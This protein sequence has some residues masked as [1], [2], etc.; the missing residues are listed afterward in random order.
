MRFKGLDLN[1]LVALD[2]LMSERSL[3]SAA[4][5][6][7]LSQ[8]AMSAAVS[9]LR[10][11]FRDDLFTM[12]GRE[13]C[14]T[15]RAEGLA[16]VVRDVLLQI[17]CSIISREPFNPA[18]S[19]RRFRIILSDFMTLVFLERVVARVAR[20]APAVSFDLL[21]PDNDPNELLRRGEVD[22]LL[23]PDLFMANPHPREKLFDEKLVCVTCPGND[24][25]PQ[26]LTF[27]QYMSMGHVV[28]M[29]GRSLR[30]SIDEWFLLERGIKRR[31][32]VVVPGFSLIPE[33]LRGTNR[34]A[35]MPLRL[36][37]YFEKTTPLRIVNL[38]LPLADFT[39]S[40]QWPA[41]Q[42]ADPASV[43]MRQILIEEASRMAAE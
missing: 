15:P 14:L 6:I 4:R 35:T 9:R 2:A 41:L 29:F 32:E 22:F 31:I 1:L 7:N 5:T 13:L 38:P 39:E 17:Q 26:E 12:N 24:A 42:N 28:A 18:Q 27:E 16:P 8:P 3:T 19:E 37:K 40:V 20:D 34:I 30:P 33:V 36:V 21:P 11:Y 23:L 25:V 10:A 43:W